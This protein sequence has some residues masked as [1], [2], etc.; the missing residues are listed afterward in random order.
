M[1]KWLRF[2]STGFWIGLFVVTLFVFNLI[3]FL[4]FTH[5][6]AEENLWNQIWLYLESGIFKVITVSLFL[7]IIL[8]FLENHFK[9]VDTIRQ[10]RIIQKRKREEELKEKRWECIEQTTKT[11][12][13]LWDLISDVVYFKKDNKQGTTIENLMIRLRNLT[14]SA[15]DVTNIWSHRFSDIPYDYYY[16][17]L[18]F[19][20]TESY[21]AETVAWCIRQ[22]NNVKK[23]EIYKLQDALKRI[24]ESINYLVHHNLINV[25]KDSMQ[26]EALTED[27]VL[28]DKQEEINELME[29]IT[30][31]VEDLKDLAK[32]IQDEEIK[33][34]KYFSFADTD[35]VKALRDAYHKL[36]KWTLEN[37][38]KDPE[39]EYKRY[40]NFR[41]LVYKAPHEKAGPCYSKEFVI[42]LANWAYLE[43]ER[44]SL[45]Y[46]SED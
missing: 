6:S 33:Q 21:S 26:L 28:G 46:R 5:A 42:Y 1:K 8:F 18:V 27:N 14:T 34:N 45:I 39:K 43:Y 35:D 15:E 4:V 24:S 9:I 32:K 13:Q 25:L 3:A 10:N 20:D 30:G 2:G 31:G 29:K 37:P 36:R 11:W 7:P 17:F 23:E 12:N 41:R 44:T 22:G 38:G 40:N 16:S 19:F